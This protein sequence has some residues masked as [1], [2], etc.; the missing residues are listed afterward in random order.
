MPKKIIFLLYTIILLAWPSLHFISAEGQS[1]ECQKLIEQFN[2]AKVGGR[3]VGEAL[4]QDL[5]KYCT[6]GAVYNK[7]GNLFYYFVGIIAVIF[8]IYGGYLYMTSGANESGKKTGKEV[9]MYTTLGM[10]S[11][12]L[13][14]LIVNLV[15]QFITG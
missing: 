15:V 13:A 6:E 9:I 11:V 12:L 7:V 5:P 3:N 4:M 14:T 8:Y 1:D 10:A 2:N